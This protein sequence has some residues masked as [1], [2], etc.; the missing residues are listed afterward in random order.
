MIQAI[1]PGEHDHHL[2]D[3]E[4]ETISSPAEGPNGFRSKAAAFHGSGSGVAT[5]QGCHTEE[6]ASALSLG[7][8][9]HVRPRVNALGVVVADVATSALTE[10]S[11][12][13]C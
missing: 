10:R 1:A 11:Y 3:T 8:K 13:L 12:S 5:S 4:N 2:D 7:D 9:G 6:L